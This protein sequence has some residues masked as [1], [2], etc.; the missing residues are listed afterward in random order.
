MRHGG[1]HPAKMLGQIF[2][3]KKPPHWVEG[4][5]KHVSSVKDQNGNRHYVLWPYLGTV[6]GGR[7][8]V[9]IGGRGGGVELWASRRGKGGDR[10][11]KVVKRGPKIDLCLAGFYEN[12][13]K[14]SMPGQG[15][16]L[17]KSL[18]GRGTR[19]LTFRRGVNSSLP[20]AP[21]P[22]MIVAISYT[23]SSVKLSVQ[24]LLLIVLL[25]M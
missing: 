24:I 10:A 14:I 13:K 11:R 2:P 19:T 22:C 8:G 21:C 7:R 16:L 20:P 15:G 12:S 23:H 3:L 18:A 4:P 1:R 17:N 6:V 5:A 9:E 25:F